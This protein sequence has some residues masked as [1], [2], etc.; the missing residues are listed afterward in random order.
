[1]PTILLQRSDCRLDRLAN[2]LNGH[3][4]IYLQC[5][6]YGPG[7]FFYPFFFGLPRLLVV[8]PLQM[9]DGARSTGTSGICFTEIYKPRRLDKGSPGP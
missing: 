4:V 8:G 3:S 9:A 1:M 2:Q 6:M 7:L 5:Y